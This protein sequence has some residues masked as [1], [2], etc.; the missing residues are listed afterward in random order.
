MA[1]QGLAIL[2]IAS[3]LTVPLGAAQDQPVQEASVAEQVGTSSEISPGQLVVIYENGELT[4][5]ANKVS[6]LEVLRRVCSQI[7]AQIEAPP[8]ASEMIVAE[9]G[10]G[11]ARAVLTSLLAGSSFNYAL[12][13][14]EEDPNSLARLVLMPLS[15][16]RQAE[17]R[18]M[19]L[20]ASVLPTS[21]LA[22]E[23]IDSQEAMNPK[24]SVAQMKDLIAE[25]KSEIATLDSEGDSSLREGATQL[26]GMLEKSMDTLVDQASKSQEQ[27]AQ[28]TPPPQDGNRPPSRRHRGR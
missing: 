2:A 7:G 25:A 14:Q 10:P 26:I 1:Q 9:L 21:D 28:S 13:A 19:P 12:Q 18:K 3:L 22:N 15:G 4:I 11:P 6:L 24:E 8:M 27:P 20:E 16:S 5:K 17:G 23:P